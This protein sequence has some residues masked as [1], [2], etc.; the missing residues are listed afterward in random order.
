VRARSIEVGDMRGEPDVA[1]QTLAGD[2][3]M[4]SDAEPEQ[5]ARRCGCGGREGQRGGQ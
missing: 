1:D 5:Q 2:N 3:R 4:R